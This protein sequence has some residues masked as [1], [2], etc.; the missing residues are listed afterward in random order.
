MINRSYIRGLH[1]PPVAAVD[2]KRYYTI[3]LLRGLAAISVLIWHYQHF[4]ALGLAPEGSRSNYPFFWILSP[5]FQNGGTAVQLF[6]IISGFVFSAVYY[7]RVHSTR[8]FIINRLA[9]LY[10]LHLVTLLVVAG[11]QIVAL[12]LYGRWLL[13]TPNDFP[14]F[15]EQLVMASGWHEHPRFTFNGP[16][17]SVSAEL[18]IYITF[19]MV[20][21]RLMKLGVI[22][23]LVAVTLCAVLMKTGWLA[24][25]WFCGIYFYLGCGVFV[26]HQNWTGRS[27]IGSLVGQCMMVAAVGVYWIAGQGAALLLAFLGLTLTVAALEETRLAA[28]SARWRWLGDSTYGIYLWH[29]PIQLIVLLI[30]KFLNVD[31]SIA[32]SP[33][34][35]LG[36][37]SMVLLAAKVSFYWIEDPAR[38]ALRRLSTLNG[39]RGSA[40]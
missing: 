37:I 5:F 26:I 2:G 9:R 33:W 6:W 1:K 34:F 4:I 25:V 27:M 13:Y 18:L 20:L 35:F 30:L 38:R 32:F 7:G 19:W 10:P 11:L 31:R 22:G 14:A 23:P 8:E 36:Y 3:D 15:L 21:P 24:R 16:I 17:W 40:I 29:I 12:R 39:A 28:W